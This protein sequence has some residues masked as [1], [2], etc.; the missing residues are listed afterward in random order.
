VLVLNGGWILFSNLLMFSVWSMQLMKTGVSFG[1]LLTLWMLVLN[2]VGVL[3]FV[4]IKTAWG[5]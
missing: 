1:K 5:L 4:A 2:G 3:S